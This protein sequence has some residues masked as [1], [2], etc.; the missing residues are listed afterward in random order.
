MM[1][2]IVPGACNGSDANQMVDHA[3]EREKLLADLLS[4][5]KKCHIRFGGRVELATESDTC[6]TQLCYAFEQIFDH[7]LLSNRND[8]RNSALR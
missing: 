1:S 8:K 6:I 2:A 4:A 5:A 7:G 3:S